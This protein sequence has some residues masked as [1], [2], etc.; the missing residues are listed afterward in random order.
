MKKGGFDWQ[1]ESWDCTVELSNIF[2]WYFVVSG[3]QFV[4]AMLLFVK[5]EAQL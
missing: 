2:C 1:N 5:Y 4:V 3:E